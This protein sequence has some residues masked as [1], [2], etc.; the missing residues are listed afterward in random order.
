LAAG[1]P[2]YCLPRQAGRPGDLRPAQAVS[3]QAAQ[4]AFDIGRALV[5]P[6]NLNLI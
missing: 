3:F 5:H 6:R 4:H 1:K 2:P